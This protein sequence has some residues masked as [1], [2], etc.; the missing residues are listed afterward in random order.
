MAPQDPQDHCFVVEAEIQE[1]LSCLA[2]AEEEEA[3]CAL[4][5]VQ[6]GLQAAIIGEFFCFLKQQ[7]EMV[8][9]DLKV[10]LAFPLPQVL[11]LLGLIQASLQNCIYGQVLIASAS[12]K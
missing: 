5:V 1:C 2:S 12:L 10:L 7:L 6:N 11:F 3:M 8:T 9:L 4:D